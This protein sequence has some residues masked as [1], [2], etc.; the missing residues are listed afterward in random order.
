MKTYLIVGGSGGIGKAIASTTVN[1]GNK[2]HATYHEKAM[3]SNTRGLEYHLLDVFKDD[4]N[5][6]YLPDV[7]DGLVYCP[8]SIN[9]KP[10]HRIKP[11]EWLSDFNLQV[12]GAVKVLQLLLPRL[13][14]SQKA[15]VVLFSTVAVQKGFNFH[16]LVSASKGAIEGLTRALAAE[17]APNIR[18]N[19]IAPSV[20]H[21]PLAERLLNTE[22]KR[23]A[24]VQKHP[25]K[26]IGEAED[27]A[28]MASFLLS[29]RSKWI[30]GQILHVD[31]G[32]SSLMT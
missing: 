19:C 6:D 28:E 25:L 24:N 10:F 32:I 13:K 1:E 31:G 26:K 2:V 8:G 15:S 30:T 22:A 12:M 18:V 14:A 16:S 27:M 5:F 29:E 17:F 3:E 11:E 7:L 4:L 20:T 23:E 21:T 9:L